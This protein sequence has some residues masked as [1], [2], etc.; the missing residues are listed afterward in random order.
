MQVEQRP[1]RHRPLLARS[2]RD[3]ARRQPLLARLHRPA[4]TRREGRR[5]RDGPSRGSVAPRAGPQ[6]ATARQVPAL[7]AGR[8]GEDIRGPAGVLGDSRQGQRQLGRRPGRGRDDH[9]ARQ[10][11]GRQPGDQ[12]A[13]PSHD[14]ELPS[15]L[16]GPPVRGPA[17]I[18]AYW[19]G[20]S[21]YA[22]AM[23]LQPAA[24]GRLASPR[25][26]DRRDRTGAP[27]SPAA[28]RRAGGCPS[29][30]VTPTYS[31]AWCR[32]AGSHETS[33]AQAFEL[34]RTVCPGSRFHPG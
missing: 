32:R 13:A 12:A 34:L 16:R 19:P 14:H 8:H 33:A 20:R 4:L 2:A 1:G 26:P 29:K 18:V 24:A 6:H 7:D 11:Q 28:V 30:P 27:R 15:R 21:R 5:D 9:A 3:S 31:D 22:A 23:A 10:R 17:S 25:R